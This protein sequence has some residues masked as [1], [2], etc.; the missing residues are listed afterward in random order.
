MDFLE[1]P[2]LKILGRALLDFI[3]VSMCLI[4]FI[5]IDAHADTKKEKKAPLQVD[6]NSSYE[7]HMKACLQRKRAMRQCEILVD[8]RKNVDD[9]KKHPVSID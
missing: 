9:A 6:L 1:H 2:A 4:F 7:E 5:T 8:A 3:G